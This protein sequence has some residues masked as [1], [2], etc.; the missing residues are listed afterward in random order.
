MVGNG[1]LPYDHDRDGKTTEL[2]G[3]TALVRNV[4]HDTFLLIRYMKNRLTVRQQNSSEQIF[5]LAIFISS[6]HGW[7]YPKKRKDR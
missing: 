2:G 5:T 7:F 4:N 1:T 6:L 3:C